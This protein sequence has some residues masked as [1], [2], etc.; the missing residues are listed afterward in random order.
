MYE[1]G[2]EENWKK[3]VCQI[4]SSKKNITKI[5]GSFRLLNPMNHMNNQLS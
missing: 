2:L 1:M 3:S 4:L 5:K